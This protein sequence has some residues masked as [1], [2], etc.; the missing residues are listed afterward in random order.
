MRLVRGTVAVVALLVLPIGVRAQSECPEDAGKVIADACP[1]DQRNHGQYVSCVVRHRND[2]RRQGCLDAAA[3]R[4]I[5]R[6]A[7][8]S[9]CG[10]EGRVVCCFVVS[11][12]ECSDLSP[13]DGMADGTCSNVDRACDTAANC[14][15]FRGRVRRDEPSCVAA[16]GQSAGEGSACTACDALTAVQ[17]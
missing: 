5:A 17:P 1:C 3:N 16:G 4:Q 15:V 12:G 9:T 13:G 14:T 10:K 6:C 7:A 2:L 8:R 11:E